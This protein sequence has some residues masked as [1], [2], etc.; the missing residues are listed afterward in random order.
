MRFN[1]KLKF[2]VSGSESLRRAKTATVVTQALRRKPE[3]DSVPV[4]DPT[5]S[6]PVSA[7]LIGL[8]AR[9]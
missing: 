9:A 5:A 3:S 2:A 6:L 1:F 8:G 4:S 7:S